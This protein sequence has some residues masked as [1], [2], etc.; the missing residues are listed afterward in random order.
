[1]N[2]ISTRGIRAISIAWIFSLLSATLSAYDQMVVFGDSLSDN[3]NLSLALGPGVL[4]ALNYD[5]LRFTNGPTTTPA[6]AI[7]GVTVEQLNQALGLSALTP[8]LLGGNNFA[9]ARATTGWT[10]FDLAQGVIPGTGTQVAAYLTS[11]PQAS[12]DSLYVMWA[13]ANDLL[14]SSTVAG[15]QQAEAAAIA[16][17][18]LQITALLEAGAKTILW[19]NLPD[20][21]LTPAGVLTG[22]TLSQQL[23]LSSLQFRQDWA[24]S[25]SSFQSRYPD[26]NVI[27][28]DTFAV[29]LA[30]VN[31]PSAF[32]LSNVSAPARGQAGIDPDQYLFWDTLHPTTKADAILAGVAAHQLQIAAI[33]E[34][35]SS[36]YV[37]VLLLGLAARRWW[38]GGK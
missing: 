7:S 35:S 27:G 26:A 18:N 38:S 34:V 10:G 9:W 3:G 13:G 5:P 17:L 36:L 23:R 20:L 2:F 21:S 24:N 15:I 28:V 11:H 4:S 31:Q 25:L 14:N 12:S 19:F 22:P 16:N 8:A 33:P 37:G 1:M 6:S 29:M 32:G 30:L